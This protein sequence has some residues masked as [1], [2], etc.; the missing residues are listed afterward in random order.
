MDDRQ[1]TKIPEET[2]KTSMHE[3]I[4]STMRLAGALYEVSTILNEEIT[5]ASTEK[6][7][8]ICL[9]QNNSDSMKEENPVLE[10]MKNGEIDIDAVQ[11]VIA[12]FK[13]RLQDHKDKTQIL[14]RV[15]RRW[16][17]ELETRYHLMK[18]KSAPHNDVGNTVSKRSE[19]PRTMDFTT[20]T[21]ALSKSDKRESPGRARYTPSS[22]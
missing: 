5:N 12:E 2:P 15:C 4:A 1:V 3:Q 18:R 20:K 16:R 10:T 8:D 9:D 19:S 17:E 14:A 21:H 7:D 11:R 22:L 6:D 13:T